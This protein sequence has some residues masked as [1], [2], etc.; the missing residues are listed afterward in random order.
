MQKT[1]SLLKTGDSANKKK[2][3]PLKV[4]FSIE[5]VEEEEEKK[6]APL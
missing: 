1:V 3:G 4:G 6:D 5:R 2:K